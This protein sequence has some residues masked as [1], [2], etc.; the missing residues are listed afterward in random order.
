MNTLNIERKSLKRQLDNLKHALSKRHVFQRAVSEKYVFLC[1][2][3]AKNNEISPRRKAIIAFG[4]EN[5]PHINFIIAEKF[6]HNMTAEGESKNILDAETMISNFSDTIVIVL[7]SP[8]ALTELGAFAHHDFRSKLVI[9]NDIQFKGEKSFI[10][11]GPIKA[12][13]E[14][15]NRNNVLYYKMGKDAENELDAIGEV[16]NDL[17]DILKQ[18]ELKRVY[19]LTLDKINPGIHFDLT[20]LMFVKDLLLCVGPVT[21]KEL[22]EISKYLFG[23]QSFDKLKSHLSLLTALDLAKRDDNNHYTSVKLDFF[24]DYRFDIY[25]LLA[26]FRNAHQK[27]NRERMYGT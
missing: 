19:A 5:L 9:I 18:D 12:I 26:A 10:N 11:E 14:V 20:S 2:A 3:T 8:G 22:V 7:E 16:Y 21:Y 25:S 27:Y 17:Y 15:G 6:F 23:V 24:F 13:E 1:G 4:K